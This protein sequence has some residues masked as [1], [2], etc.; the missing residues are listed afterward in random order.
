M[1]TTATHCANENHLCNI[2]AGIPQNVIYTVNGQNYFKD[3]NNQKSILCNNA[4][5]GDPGPHGSQGQCSVRNIPFYTIGSNGVPIGYI[6]CANEGE[7]C[8]TTIDTNILY[9][10]DGNYV[11][12]FLQANHS[13]PCNDKTFIGSLPGKNKFCYIKETPISAP[14]TIISTPTP[15]S[16]PMSSLPPV[17][18]PNATLLQT[19]SKL[20]GRTGLFYGWPGVNVPGFD[21]KNMPI[22]SNREQDCAASCLDQGCDLYAY[23]TINGNC[24]LKQLPKANNINTKFFTYAT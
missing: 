6:K 8:K 4:T 18:V 13:I 15:K 21:M 9:G 17:V 22:H 14:P 5:F 1:G 19:Q 12:G 16:I 3:I 11:S 7:I 2:Q 20:T 10:A 24:W 23:D